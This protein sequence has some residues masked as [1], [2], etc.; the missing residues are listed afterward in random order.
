MYLLLF[1][2]FYARP[3]VARPLVANA[4]YGH[5]S[6]RSPL[7]LSLRM[8]YAA[9]SPVSPPPLPGTPAGPRRNYMWATL[10]SALGG[11]LVPRTANTGDHVRFA[12]KCSKFSYDPCNDF[13]EPR[14]AKII[15][16][17]SHLV[18]EALQSPLRPAEQA[19]I[20]I[21]NLGSSR[22]Q[23]DRQ[24]AVIV[25][26][27]FA[28]DIVSQVVLQSATGLAS[29]SASNALPPEFDD[30]VAAISSMG[31]D[32]LDA[33][34]A[35]YLFATP[36]A[37]KLSHYYLRSLFL[38]ETFAS[39]FRSMTVG[40]AFPLRDDQAAIPVL[41]FIHQ[42][43]AGVMVRKAEEFQRY[44]AIT[45]AAAPS[46]PGRA[47]PAALLANASAPGRAAPAALLASASA[48]AALC[49]PA[50]LAP[51]RAAP[52]RPLIILFSNPGPAQRLEENV[53]SSGRSTLTPPEAMTGGRMYR[54][55]EA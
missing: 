14:L 31:K 29:F 54:W 27:A 46:A 5:R 39:T 21:N 19:K 12:N 1:F 41:Q 53:R 8:A 22:T 15:A 26:R 34:F 2:A 55:R 45:A 50:L 16:A 37:S 28:W 13:K 3:L 32:L 40:S 52:Y 23:S 44:M 6:S 25:L 51:G 9:A 4:T 24:L 36:A 49:W 48:P 17:N 33:Y 47:A 42:T 35:E 10:S 11:V 18:A 38:D 20:W 30:R 43:L 7:R